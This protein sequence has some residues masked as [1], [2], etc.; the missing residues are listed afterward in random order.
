M[1]KIESQNSFFD[2]SKLFENELASQS[3]SS[4]ISLKAKNVT[5]FKN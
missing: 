1:V 5:H 3:S 2:A 4:Y